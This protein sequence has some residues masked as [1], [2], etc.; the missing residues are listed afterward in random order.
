M[1]VRLEPFG[2]D[3]VDRIEAWFDDPETRTR[4]GGRGWIRRAPSF[5]TITIGEEF[6][7]RIVTGRRM[8]LAID[9]RDVP[10]AFVDAE[11]YDRY[12]AWDGSDPDEPMISDAIES[13]AVG[14][15]LVVDPARRRRGWG[16][17]TLRA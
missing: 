15:A 13:P 16:V 1:S 7:G 3:D 12:A 8:W 9:D 17:A 10:V 2:P 6:R 11:L 5:L 4:L 14:L